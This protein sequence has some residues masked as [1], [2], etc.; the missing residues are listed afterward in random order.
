MST[1]W[2]VGSQIVMAALSILT[3]KFVAVG[4]SKELAGTY[5][6]AFGFLQ[7]FG[8]LADF[9]LYA[10]AVREVSRSPQPEKVLGNIVVLRIGILA[11]SLG[12]AL[13]FVWLL[14]AW[15]GTT[16]PMAVTIAAFVPFFTLLAGLLR[17]VFQVTYTMHYVFIAEV[18]QRIL[19]TA[20]IG[21]F[22]F[23]GARHSTDI[24]LC[25]VFLLIGGIG[26][27]LL[28]LLSVLLSRNLMVIRPAVDA[29]IMRRLIRATL[30]FGAAFLC[31]ALYRQIDVTLIAMLRPD[32]ELQ[33]AYYGFVLRMAET[34]YIIPTF[35]LN[36]TLPTL[37]SLDA[38]GENTAPLLG[39]TLLSVLII[40]TVAF[41]FSL[42]WSRPLV[43]L[44]THEAYL[45]TAARAGSDT[46]LRLMAGPVFLNA[47][48]TYCFYV[49]LTR[50]A[51]RPLVMTLAWGAALSIALNLWLIPY[52]G[53]VGA[54]IT[55]IVVHVF[56]TA[57]LLPLS[58]CRMPAH[59]PAG[60]LLRWVLFSALLAAA[61]WT[62]QPFLHGEISTAFGLVS[63]T[64]LIGVLGVLCGL[65]AHFLRPQSQEAP[66]A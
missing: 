24:R 65:H 16:L 29:Q 30:P 6:S 33:N 44:L 38:R 50:H 63:M 62:Y 42:L 59:L 10:V 43:L 36:S 49:L 23:A 47:V 45:S 41:L 15:R 17:T 20:G 4:L 54:G 2:Q 34:G 53:F 21:A 18:A 51:W 48:I 11:V 61:L 1:L 25:Y 66:P 55:S 27:F 28:F 3:V 19:T 13:L 64:A 12:T 57:L 56:L 7:L 58:L 60:M 9:G 5:N 8:I 26:A 35:L 31:T 39:K 46:A 37:S 40:G 52:Y 14:P 32:F 22:I